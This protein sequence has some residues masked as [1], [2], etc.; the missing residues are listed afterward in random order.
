MKPYLLVIFLMPTFLKLSGQNI[1]KNGDFE[2]IRTGQSFPNGNE[3][4][5]F[6]K[7]QFWESR[8]S[9]DL[10]PDPDLAEYSHSPDWIYENKGSA[11][12]QGV[13]LP[14]KFGNGMIAMYEHE[15]I[16]Q[17]I[18]NQIEFG[19]KYQIS[20]YYY[21]GQSSILSDYDFSNTILKIYLAKHKLKYKDEI[22]DQNMNDICTEDYT[23]YQS[24]L[25]EQPEAIQI[26]EDPNFTI[27]QGG[28]YDNTKNWIKYSV[29][30]DI[31]HPSGCVLEAVQ[32]NCGYNWFV[33]ALESKEYVE[34][35]S[36]E[37]G[38]MFIDRLSM[39][40]ANGCEIECRE[41][42]NN[43]EINTISHYI[44][45]GGELN[46]ESSGD[47]GFWDNINDFFAE[48]LN[49]SSSYPEIAFGA[50]IKN[51]MGYTFT[52]YSDNSEIIYQRR[53]YD[54]NGLKD[55]GEDDYWIQWKGDNPFLQM[56]AWESYTF[57]IEAWNCEDATVFYD[58]L[59]YLGVP[60]SLPDKPLV[61]EIFD[62]NCCPNRVYIQNKLYT[63]PETVQAATSIS[64]GFNV[65]PDLTV[66]QGNVTFV[67]IPGQSPVVEYI[68]PNIFLDNG[69]T[70]GPNFTATIGECELYSFRYA[71]SNRNDFFRGEISNENI[72]NLGCIEKPY[73]YPNPVRSGDQ[74]YLS[75]E[76]ERVEVFNI[77]NSLIGVYVNTGLP[78][79]IEAAKG[80]YFVKIYSNQK[81]WHTQK[82]C[83]L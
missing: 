45:Q 32:P 80:V 4:A 20:F 50:S 74:I 8:T 26:L 10:N 11:P 39:R 71:N 28:I 63:N 76:I 19:K 1:I 6:D 79:T 48:L 44:C 41:P 2:M 24:P 59:V 18:G 67:T 72:E 66:P 56:I 82:I 35:E 69:F 70:S 54:V 43:I 78:V 55:P 12:N 65:N 7:L 30:V 14:A 17:D 49:G 53:E 73:F 22:G 83:V 42:L 47:G 52:V 33:L 25:S 13:P 60:I 29:I 16:Q 9:A 37:D 81:T 77:N 3:F 57:T 15:L 61:G 51:A 21:L 36:C 23:T 68:A 5:Q 31:P 75:S 38:Y 62:H 40:Q 58:Y 27:I 34:N 46:Y 64:A